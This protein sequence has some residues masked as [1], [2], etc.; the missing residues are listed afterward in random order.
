MYNIDR[1]DEKFIQ[2]RSRTSSSIAKK[3]EVNQ[4]LTFFLSYP[5]GHCV[6]YFYIN[7]IQTVKK[8]HLVLV[9]RIYLLKRKSCRRNK[10]FI[11]QQ[12]CLFICYKKP[13]S[14]NIV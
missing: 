10:F 14:E 12:K 11:Y 7:F 13:G 2:R 6:L 8:N 4:N 9:R 3:R 1:E 5:D